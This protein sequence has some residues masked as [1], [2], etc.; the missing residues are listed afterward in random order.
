MRER[1]VRKFK[2]IAQGETEILTLVEHLSSC[3]VKWGPDVDIPWMLDER[4]IRCR[5]EHSVKVNWDGPR[6][7]L[8]HS[9]GSGVKSLVTYELSEVCMGT[10][11]G[12]DTSTLTFA[13]PLN[14]ELEKPAMDTSLTLSHPVTTSFYSSFCLF[15]LFQSA[16]GFFLLSFPAPRLSYTRTFLL[17]YRQ[18]YTHVCS[19]WH[20]RAFQQHRES[21][22]WFVYFE[23]YLCLLWH[24]ILSAPILTQPFF[25]SL[26]LS[27]S[28]YLGLISLFPL[29]RVQNVQSWHSERRWRNIWALHEWVLFRTRN[30]KSIQKAVAFLIPAD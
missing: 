8:G 14:H 29:L 16:G 21:R 2:R 25:L 28:C 3:R 27:L 9:L 10:K 12:W 6:D 17:E 19:Y 13:L 22:M 1:S 5:E 24:D 4:G 7:A 23:I 20:I 15:S 26:S 18:I 11:E 30:D